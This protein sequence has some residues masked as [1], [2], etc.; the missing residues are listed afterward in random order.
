[1]SRTLAPVGPRKPAQ[2]AEAGAQELEFAVVALELFGVG[3]RSNRAKP[4]RLAIGATRVATRIWDWR[5]RTPCL[6]ASR[7]SMTSSLCIS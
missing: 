2:S 3:L 4:P 6:L 1:M 7:P 5:S